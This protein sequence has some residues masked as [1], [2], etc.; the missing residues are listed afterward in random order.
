M[1]F[2]H[3]VLVTFSDT[4]HIAHIVEELPITYGKG[5]I[6]QFTGSL[7]E[8]RSRIAHTLHGITFVG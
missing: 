7:G 1:I 3:F 2:F 5:W 4:L 8:S 6:W